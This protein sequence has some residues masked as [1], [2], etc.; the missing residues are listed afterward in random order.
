MP[1]V[2]YKIFID[3]P[4]WFSILKTNQVK[5]ICCCTKQTF[6]MNFKVHGK[7][8]YDCDTMQCKQLTLIIADTR[9][10]TDMPYYWYPY[11]VEFCVKLNKFKNKKYM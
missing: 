6:I 10:A 8:N 4:I 7:S 9:K 3:K 1:F 2:K 11:I 5:F